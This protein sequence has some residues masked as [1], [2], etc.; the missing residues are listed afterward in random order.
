LTL[1]PGD[2][3]N[4]GVVWYHDNDQ[5]QRIWKVFSTHLLTTI[6]ARARIKIFPDAPE[7]FPEDFEVK[8]IYNVDI[9]AGPCNQ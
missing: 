8:I 5:N 7:L 3:L 4:I 6:R 2:T 1:D 9:N